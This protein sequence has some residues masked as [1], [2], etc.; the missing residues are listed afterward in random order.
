MPAFNEAQCLVIGAFFGSLITHLV[1]AELHSK[2]VRDLI[3]KLSEII[4]GVKP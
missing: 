1:M 2:R 4:E 3:D